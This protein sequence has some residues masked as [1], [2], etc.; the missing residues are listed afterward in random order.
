LYIPLISFFHT[1]QQGPQ[2]T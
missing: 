2:A 1:W